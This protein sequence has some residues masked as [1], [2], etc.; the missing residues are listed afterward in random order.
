MSKETRLLRAF[1]KNED[2]LADIPPKISGTTIARIVIG[3]ATRCSYCFPHGIE[4]TNSHVANRQRSWKKQRRT[5]WKQAH[6][7]RSAG[8]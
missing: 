8:N 7:S 3:D 4:T 5:Q 1:G 2:G 6:R